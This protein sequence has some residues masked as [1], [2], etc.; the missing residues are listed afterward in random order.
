MSKYGT[1]EE[2]KQYPN[3]DAETCNNEDQIYTNSNWPKVVPHVSQMIE[4]VCLLLMMG[5][6][7]MRNKYREQDKRARQS[8][9]LQKI[10]TV[11]SLLDIF[12]VMSGLLVNYVY[13]WIAAFIRPIYMIVTI[14]LIRD[15][16]ERYLLVMTDSMPMVLFILIYILYFSW[17]GQR[18]FSGTL[19]GVQYFGSF[20]DSVFNMLVLMT[21]S[22]YPDIMLPAYQ[23][24]RWNCFFFIIYLILGLFLMMNLL[25][26]IFYS[27]F[28]MRF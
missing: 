2:R 6:Q 24:S 13:P 4:I 17:M 3:W 26:A 25:L 23:I 10:L 9:K 22:N 20:G 8:W 14:R 19:E 1:A 11:I 18:L 27:N 16:W 28:K 12:V 5:F 21:T 15:Y 7:M